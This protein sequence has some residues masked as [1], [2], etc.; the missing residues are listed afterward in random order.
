MIANSVTDGIFLTIHA[1]KYLKMKEHN[2][3]NYDPRIVK[4]VAYTSD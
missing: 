4:F 1:A 2:I 3:E